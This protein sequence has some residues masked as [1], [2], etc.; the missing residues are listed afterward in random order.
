MENNRTSDV[1]AVVEGIEVPSGLEVESARLHL[2]SD[3]GQHM[4]GLTR[5]AWRDKLDTIRSRGK[6]KIGALRSTAMT[7]VGSVRG[8]VTKSVS[9]T[10]HHL[11]THPGLWAGA[12]AGAGFTLGILGRLMLYRK[13]HSMPD[14]IVISGAC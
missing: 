9:S 6:S 14:V 11:R 5:P 8:S 13:E 4:S 7:R 12:A 10:Q 2:P 1:F 3:G